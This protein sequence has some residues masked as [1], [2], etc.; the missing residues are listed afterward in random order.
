V[1]ECFFSGGLFYV[2]MTFSKAKIFIEIR[3]GEVG[4]AGRIFMIFIPMNSIN[5]AS[6]LT[7]LSH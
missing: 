1:C 5:A 3:N 7:R 6:I 4:G 2:A